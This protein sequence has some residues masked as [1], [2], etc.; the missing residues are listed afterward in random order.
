MNLRSSLIDSLEPRRLFAALT[1]GQTIS[2][3]ITTVGQYKE[4]TL[5]LVAGRAVAI[6]AG[7]AGT[8]SFAPGLS[9]IDPAGKTVSTSSGDKGA[10]ISTTSLVTGTYKVRMKDVGNDQKGS[11]RVTA[12]YYAPTITDSD[13]AY[14][15]ESGRR[16]ASTIQPGDLDIWTI[17]ASNSQ[18]LSSLAVENK[19]GDPIGVGMQMIGPD[20]KLIKNTTSTMGTRV[21]V[22]GSKKGNYYVMIYEPGQDATG[23]YGI[24]FAQ[25]SAPQYA[26]DP[27]TATPLS[28]D[29]KRVGDLPAGDYDIF[30]LNL[31]AGQGIAVSFA[32]TTGS[33][34]PELLLIDSTG[35]VIASNNG[36]PGVTLSATVS[37]GGSYYLLL[38]DRESDDGGQYAVQYGLK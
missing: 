26:G 32:R 31:S 36:S 17:N 1:P 16:R 8:T 15:A 2:A 21:D 3:S 25:T 22:Q 4:W 23:R 10:F 28:R 34:D 35:K 33:L 6:S 19:A 11:V 24:T 27:D 7:D 29:T 37:S 30:A 14:I 9:L 20:G 38:R 12:F 5:P 18:F 13:D